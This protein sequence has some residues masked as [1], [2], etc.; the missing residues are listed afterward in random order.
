MEVF[1]AQGLWVFGF[2]IRLGVTVFEVGRGP[3]PSSEFLQPSKLKVTL[4]TFFLKQSALL[5]WLCVCVFS[6]RI[7][8]NLFT[9]LRNLAGDS[10]QEDESGN[11]VL[12]ITYMPLPLLG[13]FFHFLENV[14]S[15]HQ[16]FFFEEVQGIFSFVAHYVLHF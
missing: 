16:F 10:H 8:I 2:E 1:L 6:P 9:F 5:W 12:Y 7:P 14:K 11:T 13:Q 4:S 3:R 15:V